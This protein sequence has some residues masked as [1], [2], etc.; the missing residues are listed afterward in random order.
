[1]EIQHDKKEIELATKEIELT[2]KE[3][4]KDMGMK[5][6][7]AGFN[8]WIKA[9][10]ILI[11]EELEIKG[12]VKIMQIYEIVADEYYSTATRVERSMRAALNQI[13]VDP[14][15]YFNVEYNVHNSAFIFLL[16]ELTLEK[17]KNKNIL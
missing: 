3:I 7:L 5:M 11:E 1:M 9:V 17:L 10:T 14:K 6:Y 13:E 8:Y 16:K 4:L 2:A 15:K 12:K